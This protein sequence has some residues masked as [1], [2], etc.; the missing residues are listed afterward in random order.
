[1]R[2][3][4]PFCFIAMCAVSGLANDESEETQWGNL[5]GRFVVQG[6]VPERKTLRVFRRAE[7]FADEPLLDE[8]L[9]VNE[10]NQGL[11][12]V[13]IW[14]YRERS[15][16]RPGIHHSYA[17]SSEASVEIT[18]SARNFSPRI[19]LLRTSQTLQLV[20]EDTVGHNFRIETRQNQAYN[21]L[22][23]AGRR[24]EKSLSFTSPERIP[25]RV[26]SSI[27]PWINSYLMV[28]DHP[29]FAVTDESGCFE[30]KDLP[31]GTWRFRTW[32]ERTGYLQHVV[33]GM[34]EET[35]PR[36]QFE[37]AIKE[38]DNNMREIYIAGSS[39]DDR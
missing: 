18:S 37:I 24:L 13:V 12:N 17:D 1:M 22:V 15:E 35:W 7:A 36:G 26:A 5:C 32:H 10:K 16:P 25:A 39:F 31:I 38:G 11:A 14:L 19:A 21:L 29:F 6:E 8:S 30:I 2:H 27:Y 33:R 4:L 34:K 28:Q 23:P 9:I 20:N 3:I